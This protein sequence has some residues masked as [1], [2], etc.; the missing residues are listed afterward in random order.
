MCESEK[1]RERE[2]EVRE[3]EGERVLETGIYKQCLR[4]FLSFGLWG[5]V[6][7]MLLGVLDRDFLFHIVPEGVSEY[8]LPGLFGSLGLMKTASQYF[9]LFRPR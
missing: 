2:R 7:L 8:A 4:F 3:R 5:I 9:S 1:V 6:F